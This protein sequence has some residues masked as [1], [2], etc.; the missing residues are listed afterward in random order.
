M[1]NTVLVYLVDKINGTILLARAKR[2]ISSG[3]LNGAGGKIEGDE[4]SEKTAVR[5]AA[6]E[7]HV[8][9]KESDLVRVGECVFHFENGPRWN[10]TVYFAYR[11]EGEP[12]E[13]E[14]MED[15]AWYAINALPYENMWVDDILWLPDVFAGNQIFA[16]FHFDEKGDTI[17]DYRIKG[18]KMKNH[19]KLWR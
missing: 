7:L 15:P 6:E 1:K 2:G 14:E 3:K 18:E 10:N 19:E 17:L 8:N 4:T 12:R 9:I 13:T 11:W 16:E 5:E